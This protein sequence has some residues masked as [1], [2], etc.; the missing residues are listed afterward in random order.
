[1]KKVG[2]FFLFLPDTIAQLT[3]KRVNLLE[4]KFTW[5]GRTFGKRHLQCCETWG[6][7]AWAGQTHT[8]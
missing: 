3:E 7:P 1:M 2:L 4:N 6:V 5:A 8:S